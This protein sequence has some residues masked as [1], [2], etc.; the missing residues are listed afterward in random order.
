MNLGSNGV[1]PLEASSLLLRLV[2]IVL[3]RFEDA[4]SQLGT[5]LAESAFLL[6]VLN[7]DVLQIVH[8]FLLN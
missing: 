3:N 2:G 4:G 5:E 7:H 8:L 1:L 6:Q